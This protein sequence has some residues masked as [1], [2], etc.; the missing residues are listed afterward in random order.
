MSLERRL[1]RAEHPKEAVMGGE[2][3]MEYGW[4]LYPLITIIYLQIIRDLERR[5][6]RR[7]PLS[8]E[9]YFTILARQAGCSEYD[10]FFR[11]AE[12]WQIGK[13]RIESDFKDYLNSGVLPY[14]AKDYSRRERGRIENPPQDLN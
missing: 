10:L 11:A 2:T 3:V 12:N 1:E 6:A 9:E 7:T 13:T 4:F 14:Y 8:D 5:F